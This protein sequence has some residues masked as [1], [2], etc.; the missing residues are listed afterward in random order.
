MN[1]ME[2]TAQFVQKVVNEKYESKIVA[3][4]DILGF[5]NRIM[6]SNFAGA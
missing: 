5:S 4:L 1:A 3:F 2:K 6:T